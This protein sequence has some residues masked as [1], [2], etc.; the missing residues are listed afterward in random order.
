MGTQGELLAGVVAPLAATAPHVGSFEL[1][2]RGRLMEGLEQKTHEL[3]AEQEA[4]EALIRATVLRLQAHSA[5]VDVF[6][7]VITEAAR[8]A[9]G[10]PGMLVFATELQRLEMLVRPQEGR[11]Q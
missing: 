8:A 7:F 1:T 5:T 10:W 11:P 3:L 9:A 2:G 4:G 6:C